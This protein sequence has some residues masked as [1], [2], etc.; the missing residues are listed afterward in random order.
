MIA[1]RKRKVD[2]ENR[3]FND[4]W[5]VLYCFVQHQTNVICLLCHSTVAVAKVS[6]IKRTYET[7][8]QEF[9]N[10]VGDERTARIEFQRR[11]LNRQQNIFSKQSADFS[12]A[13]EVS[14]KIS[15]M[16]AKSGRPF[17]DGNFVKQCMIT[18]S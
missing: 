2:N 15:L 6:N 13:C 3:Q 17:T 9:H 7:K 16:I 4:D 1:N 18:A 11:S 14:Y 8:H 5:T 10:V 12:A